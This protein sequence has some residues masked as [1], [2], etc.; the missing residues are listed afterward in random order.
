MTQTGTLGSKGRAYNT[1]PTNTVTLKTKDSVFY[2]YT[3]QAQDSAN[4]WKSMGIIDKGDITRTLEGL[5][6]DGSFYTGFYDIYGNP[7]SGDDARS[8]YQFTVDLTD[9]TYTAGTDD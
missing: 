9:K 3:N 7:Y 5:K 4:G 1:D 2:F 8:W 6:S